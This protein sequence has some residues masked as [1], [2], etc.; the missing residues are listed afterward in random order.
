MCLGA[1]KTANVLQFKST[2]QG[3]CPEEIPQSD[4]KFLGPQSSTP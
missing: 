2:R 1:M 4:F 3:E